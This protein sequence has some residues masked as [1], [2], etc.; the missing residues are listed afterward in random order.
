MDPFVP[1]PV[2]N[3]SEKE[4]ESCYLYYMDRNWLQHPHSKCVCVCVRVCVCV[5]VCA[6]V[7][8]CV[9]ACVCVCVCAC[10]YTCLYTCLY[11]CVRA[12]YLFDLLAVLCGAAG[13]VDAQ[14]LLE[15]GHA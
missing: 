10:V 14:A 13:G 15:H 8:V 12:C 1:V 5:C 3:Y 6:C 9:C 2:S 11:T 4:S 7:C